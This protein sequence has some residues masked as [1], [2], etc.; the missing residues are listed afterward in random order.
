MPFLTYFQDSNIGT[1]RSTLK[2]PLNVEDMKYDVDIT[3]FPDDDSVWEE[4]DLDG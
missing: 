1:F 4:I 3:D 2:N